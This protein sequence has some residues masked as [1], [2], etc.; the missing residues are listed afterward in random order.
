MGAGIGG[1]H[2]G[3][4]PIQVVALIWHPCYGGMERV[5]RDQPAVVDRIVHTIS[6]YRLLCCTLLLYTQSCVELYSNNIC[7]TGPLYEVSSVQLPVGG[8][9]G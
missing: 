6:D 8:L 9:P 2:Q 1:C 5:V 3:G 4:C 7:W